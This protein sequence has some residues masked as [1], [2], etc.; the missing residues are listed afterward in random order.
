MSTFDQFEDDF[1]RIRIERKRN[2]EKDKIRE[3]LDKFK[4]KP[5][6]LESYLKKYV[7]QQDTACQM[8][9][10][11]VCTHFNR[12]RYELLKNKE[13]IKGN[14]KNNIMMIGPTGVG[15]TFIIKLIADKLDVPFSKG[16]A[17]KYSET[18]YIGGDVDDLVRNLYYKS[19]N[20][21]EKAQ[22]G[23]VYVDEIDKIASMGT[24][25]NGPDVSRGGVQ[26]SLLKLMEESEVD[27]KTPHDIA[28][29]MESVMTLQK[30]GK[31][32]KKR[33][34]TKNIL[35]IFS[36]AFDGLEE[37]IRKRLN[38]KVIGFSNEKLKEKLSRDDVYKR[39]VPDDLIKFGFESEFIGRIPISIVLN[40][41]DEDALFK[42]LMNENSSIIN[43]KKRDF[44]SYGIKLDFEEDALK[45]VAEKAS[46][47]KTGARSLIRILENV[48]V[49]YERLL[50]STEIKEFKITKDIVKDPQTHIKEFIKKENL[51]TIFEDLLLNFNFEE[52][53]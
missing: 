3:F 53:Q 1:N 38:K 41:L 10:T 40:S 11:K 30:T 9:S 31:N 29:Q 22:C 6:E 23:I 18:G 32:V 51:K 20:D 15:K 44:K 50:P 25:G 14:I 26:R 16:D 13:S 47:E 17:T 21:I 42:I 48:L 34:N 46:K 45:I 43:S 4:I 19:D 37:I 8:I 5:L 36:G 27:I 2:K 28:S 49:H 35:F 52:K 24:R 39:V 12:L 33:I 7:I